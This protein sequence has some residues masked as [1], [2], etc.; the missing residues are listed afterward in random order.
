MRPVAK[1]KRSSLPASSLWPPRP[2]APTMFCT[3]QITL[4]PAAP[5]RREKRFSLTGNA[6]TRWAMPSRSTRI[7]AAA[8]AAASPAVAASR[9][10]S[11]FSPLGSGS[12]GGR[13]PACRAIR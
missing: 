2:C 13:P 11:P 1:S 6:A 12:N 4:R 8:A 9:S 10:A 7:G 3:V 5:A